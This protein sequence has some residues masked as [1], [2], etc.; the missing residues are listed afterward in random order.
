MEHIPIP[1]NAQKPIQVPLYDS[2]E[3]DGMGFWDF[4]RRAG[5]DLRRVQ[6]P[7]GKPLIGPWLQLKTIQ[8]AIDFLESPAADLSALDENLWIMGVKDILS[9]L[10]AI[11]ARMLFESKHHVEYHLAPDQISL[12]TAAEF[13]LRAPNYQSRDQD[14]L[15]EKL[16][17]DDSSLFAKLAA[18]VPHECGWITPYGDDWQCRFY[19]TDTELENSTPMLPFGAELS[20]DNDATSMP[21]RRMDSLETLPNPPSIQTRDPD[22]DSH[23]E[24][25]QL[26]QLEAE[27][28]IDDMLI[29]KN[30]ADALDFEFRVLHEEIKPARSQ[31]DG[32][33][34]HR[35]CARIY[36]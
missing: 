9:F 14:Q 18:I 6:Q 15:D 2:I 32:R 26:E 3:Y 27:T 35:P 7:F 12:A 16:T 8:H 10:H 22:E 17:K 30:I 21:M 31:E 28:P 23:R 36:S 29:R 4:P 1:Q 13:C 5:F 20:S 33:E 24:E 11:S 25:T 34:A 19:S